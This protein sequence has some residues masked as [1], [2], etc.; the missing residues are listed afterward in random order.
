MK[1]MNLIS[2]TAYLFLFQF[3]LNCSL[4]SSSKLFGI[5]SLLN[6]SS[7]IN[8]FSIGGTISGLTGTVTLQ[9]NGADDLSISTNGN[10]TFSKSL[11]NNATYSVTVLN[12]PS[13]QSCTVSNGTGTITSSNISNVSISCSNLQY[14][15]VSGTIT[16]LSGTVILQNNGADNLSLT[17]NGSFNFGTSIIDG[18]TYS[19]TVSSQPTNKNCV[20]T[21]PSGTISSA[22][23]SNITITC[24][25][26]ANGAL[27][28]GTIINP[29]TLTGGVTTFTGSPCAAN[30][31]CGGGT[32][33]FSDTATTALVRFD[34]P[35]SMTTDGYYLYVADKNNNRIRKVVIA[36]GETTTLAGN[37]TQALVDGTGTGAQ[38][39]DP[40][41][42]V[43]DG[44]N[45]YVSD[46]NNKAIRKVNLTTGVVT[47]IISGSGSLQDPKGMVIYN[48]RLYI[49]DKND[50]AILQLDLST[51]ALT[52]VIPSTSS[53]NDPNSMTLVGT[54][55]YIADKGKD[56]ILKTTIGTWTISTFAGSTA[57]YTNA[58]GLLA[59]FDSPEH[60]TTDGTNLYVTDKNNEAIRKIVISTASVSTLAGPTSAGGASG[61]VN[62]STAANARF[63]SIGGIVSDGLK[64]FLVDKNNHTIRLIQ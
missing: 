11:V 44:V 36:T 63:D 29:L 48:N 26:N 10:F 6:S 19:V 23:V 33:G 61:Y 2:L 20:I 58:I 24:T 52:T 8:S 50:K 30:S 43:T 60:I 56:S 47:T 12:Q 46:K 39:E 7:N 32:S 16:G 9:N 25:G 34:G 13:G 17:T 18:S 1:R 22:N 3:F 27:V 57:G 37:G 14:Y 40:K 54:D 59:K 64:L 49:A 31:S 45:L 42:L 41:F 51:N 35:E 28:S 4:N 21:N 55:I 62:S 53:I 38:F 15:T 5:I